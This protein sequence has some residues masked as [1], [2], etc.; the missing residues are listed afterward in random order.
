MLIHSSIR[1]L[2]ADP[3]YEVKHV[4]S[5]NLT[6]P[7]S[8]TYT[9]DRK[10]ALAREVRTH[11]AAL[12]GVVAVT[13]GRA[14]VG[15]GLHDATVSLNGEKPSAQSTQGR[16]FYNYVEANYFETLGIRILAGSGF[17]SQA[18]PAEPAVILSE[19]AAARFWP[20]QN[21]IG[22]TVRLGTDWRLQPKGADLPDGPIYRVIAIAADTLG[23]LPDRSDTAKAYLQLPKDRLFAYPFLVR[24]QGEPKHLIG[25]VDPMLSSIDP[26]LVGTSF[27]LQEV[28]RLTPTVA[29]PSAAAAIAIAVGLAGL[30]LASMGIYGT[31]SYMVVL[32][33]REVGIRMALG[34]KKRDVIVLMLSDVVRPVLAGLL[35][36]MI[37]AVGAS[38][39]LRQVL[40][41]LNS[42][43]GISF[44]G[45]ALLF[46]AIALLASY[47]PS[48]RATRVDPIAALRCE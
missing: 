1:A 38:Y 30:L 34:A 12:P 18:G 32:R 39:L 2:R 41:G 9:A 17:S 44:G 35:A 28:F 45:V 16:V 7:E 15:E 14:P 11:L 25:A 26:N 48:R 20:G 3:G 33:T 6:F 40:Y 42:V 22:R 13:T 36:G 10:G 43:D 4:V 24:T 29:I 21:P 8:S 47:L 19:S 27:T 31:V 23:A 46:L 5:I 37:L